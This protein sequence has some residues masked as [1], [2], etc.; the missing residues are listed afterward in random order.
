MQNDL[1][2]RPGQADAIEISPEMISGGVDA[3]LLA[4]PTASE[5]V[6][7]DYMKLPDLVN[8]IVSAALQSQTS[9]QG[10]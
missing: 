7:E 8:L 5:A 2:H 9:R 1:I 10:S 3:F 4:S 6:L